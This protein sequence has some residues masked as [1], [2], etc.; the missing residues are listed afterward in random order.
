MAKRQLTLEKRLSGI[1]EG[2]ADVFGRQI[3][4]FRHNVRRGHPVRHHRDYC[5][6]GYTQTP[7]TGHPAH[8]RWVNRDSLVRHRPK[9]TRFRPLLR[10]L[11]G[12]GQLAA[13]PTR[14]L[15][16][17][18]SHSNPA[19]RADHRHALALGGPVAVFPSIM[20]NPAWTTGP[21]LVGLPCRW[22]QRAG[23]VMGGL[24]QSGHTSSTFRSAAAL[25]DFLS[26]RG[27][28]FLVQVDDSDRR[29]SSSGVRSCRRR[30]RGSGCGQ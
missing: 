15:W 27:L 7:D 20:V 23:C 22:V 17:S 3:R 9:N 2:V 19:P 10:E 6:D 21:S 8:D 29:G 28:A 26:C 14:Q 13:T 18:F 24:V 1:A 4:Q 30:P 12:Y 11:G 5:R 25:M 16:S